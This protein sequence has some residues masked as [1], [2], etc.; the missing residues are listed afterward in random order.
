VA[1]ELEQCLAWLADVE[2]ADDFRVLREGCQEVGVVRGGGEAE[3]GRRVGHGLLGEGGGDAAGCGVVV[4]WVL[5]EV[6][7]EYR[8][9]G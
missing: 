7:S 9:W 1:V 3:E 5:V 8:E 4:W 6:S 2:D